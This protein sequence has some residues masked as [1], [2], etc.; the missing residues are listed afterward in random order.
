MARRFLI[1]TWALV[2]L[3]SLATINPAGAQSAL[4]AQPVYL[5]VLLPQGAF[6]EP[7][8]LATFVELVARTLNINIT[9]QGEIPGTVVFNAPVPV[10]KSELI[11][12]LALNEEDF[13]QRFRG[14]PILRA[15]RRGFLRNVAV[16]QKAGS[17]PGF[18]G[19]ARR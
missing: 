7:V 8:Q 19:R 4:R 6:A 13:R 15:K 5:R 9:T 3:A 12:L 18:D 14:S 1:F 11:P 17:C 2:G 10:K 16:A